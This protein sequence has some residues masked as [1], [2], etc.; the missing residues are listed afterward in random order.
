VKT[1]WFI[2]GPETGPQS[3]LILLLLFLNHWN[4]MVMPLY[5]T[6]ITNE[7]GWLCRWIIS[8]M[9]MRM[10]RGCANARAPSYP[11]YFLYA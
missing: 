1:V 10:W 9:F 7:L 2:V 5:F 4:W 6:G 8:L 3:L 11:G